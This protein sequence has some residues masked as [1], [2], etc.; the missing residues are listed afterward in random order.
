M[1]DKPDDCEEQARVSD[2]DAQRAILGN[3]R[4][5]AERSAKRWRQLAQPEPLA[6]QE[7]RLTADERLEDQA[8][9]EATT[10]PT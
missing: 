5:R 2:A 9:L 1:P 7:D 8:A 4:D 10:K 3:V 6:A